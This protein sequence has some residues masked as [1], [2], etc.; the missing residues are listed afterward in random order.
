MV[1]KSEESLEKFFRSCLDQGAAPPGQG[2]RGAPCPPGSPQENDT[3]SVSS[4][5]VSS[6]V[7]SPVPLGTNSDVASRVVTKR[8]RKP[9]C[10]E[11]FSVFADTVRSSATTS[12]VCASSASP[13]LVSGTFSG[14]L[15]GRV[16]AVGANDKD[17]DKYLV[18]EDQSMESVSRA[19]QGRAV[20]CRLGLALLS[21]RAA[22][23]GAFAKDCD[24]EPSTLR[25]YRRGAR[26]MAILATQVS[27]AVWDLELLVDAW[28]ALCRINRASFK[29][30]LSTIKACLDVEALEAN[31]DA[32]S[33]AE[34]LAFAEELFRLEA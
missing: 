3:A 24:L 19:R 11:L 10:K 8:K 14:P 30:S 27:P 7:T 26:R 2:R 22:N 29:H 15:V 34:I 13:V 33:R 20:G 25:D 28:T 21:S 12:L 23:K 16:D 31:L 9:G 17:K 5:T 6:P 32:E 18:K 1:K 4:S